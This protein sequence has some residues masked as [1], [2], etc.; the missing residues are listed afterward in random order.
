VIDLTECEGL[1]SLHTI[2]SAVAEKAAQDFEIKV[3]REQLAELPSLLNKYC[4]WHYVQGGMV[5]H[6]LRFVL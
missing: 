6:G 4:N 2:Y 1:L 5:A 3:T